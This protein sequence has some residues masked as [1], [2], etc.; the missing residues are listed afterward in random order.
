MN[1]KY[2]PGQSKYMDAI[3]AHRK[4]QLTGYVT[5]GFKWYLKLYRLKLVMKARKVL[6]KFAN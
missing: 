4:H 3:M 6:W 5:R 1:Y 2:E